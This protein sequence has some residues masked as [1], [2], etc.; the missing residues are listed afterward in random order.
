MR[1]LVLRGGALGDLVVST[2]ALFALRDRFP[3]AEIHLVG[4]RTAAELLLD[5]GIIQ[6]AFSQ[7][8]SRWSALYADAPLPA[9]LRHFLFEY[10]IVVSFWNDPDGVLQ[11]H[12]SSG[13]WRFVA[14]HGLVTSRPASLHFCEAIAP[15]GAACRTLVPRLTPSDAALAAA[16][17]LLGKMSGFVAIHPGSGSPKKNWPLQAWENLVARLTGPVLLVLGEAEAEVPMSLS[18]RSDV[19]VARSWSLPALAAALSRSR[20]Y[21][22]HDTGVSHVAAAVGADCLLLFGPTDPQIWAPPG[23]NVTVLRKSEA[24]SAITVEDVWSAL[25]RR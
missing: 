12:L 1:I 10:E 9:S 22:G 7:H 20:V 17:Q 2:P 21:V 4:N 8:E 19:L 3:G 6:G 18:R 15:L 25:F 11:G 14:S 24:V 16:D 13:P 23:P 5:A